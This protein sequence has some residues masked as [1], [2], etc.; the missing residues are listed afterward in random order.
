MIHIINVIINIFV[1]LISQLVVP[2]WVTI[3]EILSRVPVI[4]GLLVLIFLILLFA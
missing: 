3:V 1:W 4:G 2:L